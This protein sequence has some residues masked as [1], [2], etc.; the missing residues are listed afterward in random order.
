[1]KTIL[2]AAAAFMATAAASCASNTSSRRNH[3][4]RLH[5]ESADLR[6]GPFDLAAHLWAGTR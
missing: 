5:I 1:M 3:L 2:A 4:W 6:V